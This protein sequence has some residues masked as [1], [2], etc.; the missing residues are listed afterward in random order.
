MYDSEGMD[1]LTVAGGVPICEESYEE[2]Q[3]MYI[4]GWMS[5]VG[6]QWELLLEESTH[7]LDF[8]FPIYSLHE[9][10]FTDP[11]ILL[12]TDRPYDL[13]T[14]MREGIG[15]KNLIMLVL[16]SSPNTKECFLQQRYGIWRRNSCTG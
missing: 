1:F 16:N 8:G 15:D 7:I 9:K 10:G 4:P 2:T 5:F 13:Q 11:I 3:G 6:V 12:N 14:C